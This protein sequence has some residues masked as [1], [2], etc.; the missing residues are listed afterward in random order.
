[1]THLRMQNQNHLE[2]RHWYPES[3]RLV[4]RYAFAFSRFF[5]EG[6]L[7][8]KPL[9]FWRISDSFAH[10]LLLRSLLARE[11]FSRGTL[12]LTI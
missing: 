11:Y 4:R 9:P 3:T 1:M 12:F 7:L 10:S 2:H 8:S 6:H 5:R